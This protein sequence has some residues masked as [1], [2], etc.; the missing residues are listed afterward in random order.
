MFYGNYVKNTLRNLFILPGIR[1]HQ[2]LILSSC[3]GPRT[4]DF[5]ESPRS[6]FKTQSR[7]NRR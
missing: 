5:S 7:G 1:A 3:R 4:Q 6:E 2:L